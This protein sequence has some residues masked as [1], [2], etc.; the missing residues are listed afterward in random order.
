MTTDRR[1]QCL[2]FS[3]LYG[4]ESASRMLGITYQT[5]KNNLHALYQELGVRSK[6]EAA[7]RLGW[8]EIP[9]HLK[10]RSVGARDD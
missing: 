7:Y 5:M 6:G 1:L 9:E 4:N 2:A 10:T 3:L 8:I